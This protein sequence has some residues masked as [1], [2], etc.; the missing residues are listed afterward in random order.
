MKTKKIFAF[1]LVFSFL[2]IFLNNS[3][4]SVDYL[5]KEIPDFPEDFYNYKHKLIYYVP[6]SNKYG[7]ILYSTDLCFYDSTSDYL[8]LGQPHMRFFWFPES[9]S[10]WSFSDSSTSY[11]QLAISSFSLC[12]IIYSDQNITYKDSDEVFFYSTQLLP[13]TITQSVIGGIVWQTLAPLIITILVVV[14]FYIGFRKAFN[15]FLKLFQKA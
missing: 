15:L 1:L 7:L 6:S 13:S 10:S 12:S 9:S 4:A 8:T 11:T 14:A 3:F 5:G 2:F